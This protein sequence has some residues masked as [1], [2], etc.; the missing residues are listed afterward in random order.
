MEKLT[1]VAAL[2]I[3]VRSNVLTPRKIQN[4]I[5]TLLLKVV[6][7]TIHAGGR[8]TR[9]ISVAMRKIAVQTSQ[10]VKPT[11]IQ[12][13]L[14]T[15]AVRVKVVGAKLLVARAP[16]SRVVGRKVVGA[17][18]VVETHIHHAVMTKVTRV[19]R[20]QAIPGC[21][22]VPIVC[23]PIILPIPTL[24]ARLPKLQTLK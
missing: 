14:E 12:N 3:V 17:T 23:P 8:R 18:A 2:M 21:Y 16:S 5:T 11:S 7:R 1:Q 4:T 10:L 24:Q 6:V 13:Q 15:I 9:M 22:P 19:L 20:K